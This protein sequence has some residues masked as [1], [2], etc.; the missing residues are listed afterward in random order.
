MSVPRRHDMQ[1]RSGPD[2]GP[3]QQLPSL[4]SIFGPP[5]P[6]RPLISPPADRPDAYTLERQLEQGA[7]THPG[8]PGGAS[9]VSHHAKPYDRNYEHDRQQLPS[10]PRTL[11]AHDSAKYSSPMKP[12][13]EMR[14]EEDV[15]I[16]PNWWHEK[17]ALAKEY[18]QGP[19][20]PYFRSPHDRFHY[21]AFGGREGMQTY[22][23]QPPAHPPPPPSSTTIPA[24]AE[25]TTTKDGLGPK[26]WTGTHFLPR[27]VKADNVPGEGMCF[28][29]DDGTHCKTVIDGETVNAHWGV[30]KAGKPRKRL[31]IACV[32][33]REKK[34]KCDPDYP[35]CVQC[36]KFGRV[37]RFKN[38]PR[39][40]HNTS[41]TLA[42]A[43]LDMP[44]QNTT[45]P[46]LENIPP[47]SPPQTSRELPESLPS[48]RQ[49]IDRDSYINSSDPPPAPPALDHTKSEPSERSTPE[50]PRIS[51]T[52]L[53]RAQLTDPFTPN[54][55]SISAVVS[56]FFAYIES[57]MVLCFVPQGLFRDWMAKSS[58][59]SAE[60]LMLFY[61]VLAVGVLLSG[62]SE[63]VA[64]EYAQVALHA[65]RTA[66]KSSLQ[67]AQSRIL[68][69]L[70]LILTART[71]ESNEMMAAAGGT[72]AFLQLTAEPEESEESGQLNLPLGMNKVSYNESRRRTMWSLFMLER[73]NSMFPNR[74]AMLNPEDI[75]ARFPVESVKFEQQQE[76]SMPCFD[77]Q[78]TIKEQVLD[79]SGYAVDIVHMWANCQN[80]L[81]RSTRRPRLVEVE[82]PK[83]EV[84]A[85]QLDAWYEALPLDMQFTWENLERADAAG[86]FALFLTCHLLYHLA[87]IRLYRFKQVIMKPQGED[88][89]VI[90]HKAC[91]H[92]K[93]VFELVAFVD[94]AV[95]IK[96]ALQNMLPP[97]FAVAAAEAS[98]VL[99]AN[100]PVERVDEMIASVNMAKKLVDGMKICR[101]EASTARKLINQRQHE[102]F[103]MRESVTSTPASPIQSYALE[104]TTPE[105]DEQK[106][107]NYQIADSMD[108]SYQ[109]RGMES[110]LEAVHI[111]GESPT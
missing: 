84:L 16:D 44:R 2:P 99:C 21:P 17:E 53:A 29:Y 108:R 47:L 24:P 30:T 72:A 104:A 58:K 107:L 60:D 55:E 64:Y 93:M 51:D 26:I 98:E 105:M 101:H 67:L 13:G 52:L 102:L 14:T 49:K 81:Y 48:K 73:L 94:K 33:C 77:P 28:F 5:A 9:Q 68:L 12:L 97:A 35:R 46:K 66:T 110:G 15:K 45:P 23:G 88:L 39:G 78:V 40:G 18:P 11:D 111:R 70:Y 76:S 7:L 25:T 74:F 75:Y 34:I 91:D 37:C 27:F 87:I 3:R 89:V 100:G 57:T 103:I 92:T 106:E 19:R 43:E 90:L 80:A 56:T 4:S 31:A 95:G 54:P 32:T 1:D 6:T 79:V 82:A 85:Q 63:Q 22:R 86:N 62:D 109:P 36:E 61:S 71:H 38:A 10:F 83:R 96:P 8:Y 69:A 41:P 65:Q 50:M 59:K 20:E 42:H